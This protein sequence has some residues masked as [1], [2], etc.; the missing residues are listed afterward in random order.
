MYRVMYPSLIEGRY[1]CHM[2]SGTA[3]KTIEEAEKLLRKEAVRAG[4][5]AST[6]PPYI[7]DDTNHIVKLAA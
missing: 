3:K 5:L 4:A 7:L 1:Q 6:L 2:R